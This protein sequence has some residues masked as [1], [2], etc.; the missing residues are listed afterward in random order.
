[1]MNRYNFNT[2]AV[3]DHSLQDAVMGGRCCIQAMLKESDRSGK[4]GDSLS[5][6]RW[7]AQL[8]SDRE[9]GIGEFDRVR[10]STFIPHDW[11]VLSSGEFLHDGTQTEQCAMF[12]YHAVGNGKQSVDLILAGDRWV[13]FVLGKVVWQGQ[14]I[15]ELWDDWQVE[16]LCSNGYDGLIRVYRNGIKI[17]SIYNLPTVDAGVKQIYAKVGPYIW[18][19]WPQVAG[20]RSGFII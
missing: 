20:R 15:K 16:I 3:G 17:F 11:E 18:R 10:F 9:I 19:Q 4:W 7:R 13:L 1:M 5:T 6:P 14:M 8:S 2:Q 12:C